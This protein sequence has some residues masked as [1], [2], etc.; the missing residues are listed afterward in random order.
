MKFASYELLTICPEIYRYVS[1]KSL[2]QGEGGVRPGEGQK[3][4]LTPAPQN[5]K[6]GGKC[7]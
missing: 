3:I 5:E 7:C 2:D 6:S 1:S 4:P